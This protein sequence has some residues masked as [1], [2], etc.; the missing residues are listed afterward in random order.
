MKIKRKK[1]KDSG[2]FGAMEVFIFICLVANIVSSS[3]AGNIHAI[4]AWCICTIFFIIMAF[5]VWD[6]PEQIN[7]TFDTT[8]KKKMDLI[9]K[10]GEKKHQPE[11]NKNSK[12]NGNS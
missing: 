7:I 6:T 3:I 4:A 5:V 9:F 10:H 2:M 12:E 1:G 8:D 11:Q